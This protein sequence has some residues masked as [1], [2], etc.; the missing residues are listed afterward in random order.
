MANA[1]RSRKLG[2]LTCACAMFALLGIASIQAA[3]RADGDAI[4]IHN[5]WIGTTKQLIWRNEQLKDLA[6]FTCLMWGGSVSDN[7]KWGTGTNNMISQPRGE[8]TGFVMSESATSKVVQFRFFKGGTIWA[9]KVTFTQEGD[10]VYAQAN[11]ARYNNN[12]NVDINVNLETSYMRR[13]ESTCRNLII[14]YGLRSVSGDGALHDPSAAARADC[15]SGRPRV[16]PLFRAGSA[17]E[18]CETL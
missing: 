10:D 14:G 17:L 13:K 5:G 6:D 9:V 7:V 1:N 4:L 3:E 2:A 12:N 15:M 16:H 18:E 11:W 8:A